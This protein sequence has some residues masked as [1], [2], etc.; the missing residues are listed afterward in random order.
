MPAVSRAGSPDVVCSATEK[1][2]LLFLLLSNT[3]C[4]K[5]V[6][7]INNYVTQYIYSQ[8]KKWIRVQML[9]AEVQSNLR[10]LV[11]VFNICVSLEESIQ[12]WF[13]WK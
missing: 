6:T 12:N 5:V 3:Q 11:E 8:L 1:F 9:I 7:K 2:F 13:S 4:Y 10:N